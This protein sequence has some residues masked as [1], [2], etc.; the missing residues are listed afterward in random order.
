MNT[1][2][3]CLFSLYWRWRLGYA[4]I[5][6]VDKILVFRIV[7]LGKCWSRLKMKCSFL[8]VTSPET[9]FAIKY[10]IRDTC[11][12]NIE[13]LSHNQNQV[14][15]LTGHPQPLSKKCLSMCTFSSY[16]TCSYH[17]H[18]CLFAC[19]F[20]TRNFISFNSQVK[21]FIRLEFKSS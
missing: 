4:K 18:C 12:C 13:N 3:W 9:L 2:F 1:S 7:F 8:F 10:I 6:F 20:S 11:A 5:K 14:T 21:Y 17:S 15:T 16:S 19:T